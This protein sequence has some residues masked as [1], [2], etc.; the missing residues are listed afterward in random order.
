MKCPQCNEKTS[1]E[2]SLGYDWV[3]KRKVCRKCR[4]HNYIRRKLAGF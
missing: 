1:R 2:N 3:Q 4:Q